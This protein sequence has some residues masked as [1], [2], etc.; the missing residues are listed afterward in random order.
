MESLQGKL[1]V[2]T[3]AATG[4]GRS[5]A[6][7]L[8]REGCHVAICDIV[9]EEMA[10]TR[11][12]CLEAAPAGTKV[13]S[14]VC[15]VSDGA[16]V[17]AF[18][19][20]VVHDHATDQLQLLFNNAGIA[21]GGSFFTDSRDQWERV[22]NVCW[23]GV[24]LTTRAFMPLMVASEW[25]HLVNTSSVNG[26]WA[27]L[28]PAIPQTAYGAAKFAVKGF[29]EALIGDLRL[30]APHIKVSVV[31]PGHVGTSIAQNSLLLHGK[32]PPE[33]MTQEEL[34]GIR[35]QVQ[36]TGIDLSQVDDATLRVGIRKK[37]DDFRDNAPL[38][39]DQ[40]AGIILDGV[41]AGRWRI[42][43]GEDAVALDRA[44]RADPEGA[45]EVAFAE[46][47]GSGLGGP[48]QEGR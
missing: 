22:F 34:H 30:N 27:S 3:G 31:M 21:G 18:R 13:S 26:F 8:A 44:V 36:R 15:D 29:S 11:A 5:L 42:L 48:P 17:E 41:R 9:V 16:Q 12:A 20:A 1:A 38:G 37:L 47:L 35:T 2:V 23:S 46:R 10:R 6:L 43:V 14:H 7:Q 39:P 19:D 32:R 40:A 33:E 45:Y 25:T 24:Y 28:G 4:M